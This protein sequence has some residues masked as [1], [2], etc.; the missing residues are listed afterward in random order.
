MDKL[1]S[2]ITVTYSLTALFLLSAC[3]KEMQDAVTS[4]SK[5]ICSDRDGIEVSL[6]LP[7]DGT[8]S[9]STAVETVENGATI[10]FYDC[11]T[12][13]LVAQKSVRGKTTSLI[14]S[15]QPLDSCRVY[16]VANTTFDWP[17]IESEV[18]ERTIQT[19]ATKGYVPRAT[20]TPATWIPGQNKG[21]SHLTLSL[22]K[23]RTRLS[24]KRNVPEGQSFAASEIYLENCP[25][26]IYP[27]L[28]GESEQFTGEGDSATEDDLNAFNSGETISLYAPSDGK[29][30]IVIRGTRT[31]TAGVQAKEKY[32]YP[33]SVGQRQ[34]MII[35]DVT[36]DGKEHNGSTVETESTD[37]RTV[38]FGTD[39]LTFADG[40]NTLN[41]TTVK[42]YGTG[43]TYTIS[44][45]GD[46]SLSGTKLYVGTNSYD[47][48]SNGSFSLNA[49]EETRLLINTAYKGIQRSITL[50][51]TIDGSP[52]ASLVLHIGK[53]PSKLHLTTKSSYPSTTADELSEMIVFNGQDTTLHVFADFTDGTNAE[54]SED[55]SLEWMFFNLGESSA[56][57]QTT[58]SGDAMVLKARYGV[59][60]NASEDISTWYLRHSATTEG[61]AVCKVDGFSDASASFT[62]YIDALQSVYSPIVNWGGVTK[63]LVYAPGSTM[64]VPSSVGV[65]YKYT[66]NKT[67]VIFSDNYSMLMDYTD[68][69]SQV[70]NSR[71]EGD[72][73]LTFKTHTGEYGT[74]STPG[75]ISYGTVK[76]T[77]Y[78]DYE[79]DGKTKS[80]SETVTVKIQKYATALS[81][82][83][84]AI[85]ETNT[86]EVYPVITYND[87]DTCDGL[88][89]SDTEKKSLYQKIRIWYSGGTYG[90]TTST[91]ESLIKQNANGTDKALPNLYV[92]YTG[93]ANGK[94][95]STTYKN[96]PINRLINGNFK[97]APSIG[98]FYPWGWFKSE[99]YYLNLRYYGKTVDNADK[100]FDYKFKV[101]TN[102]NLNDPTI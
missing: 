36:L 40:L 56:E 73:S 93:T 65:I 46:S 88:Y 48:G 23:L 17:K 13:E 99:T 102:H 9:S 49:G 25:K 14:V 76:V 44:W 33:I 57:Y 7:C 52:V 24:I 26:Y 38:S 67:G 85:E 37:T 79:L 8:K 101:E 95:G 72:L 87:G 51:A 70:Q 74:A 80:L 11:N 60:E 59:D 3:S 10:A 32:S 16:A 100:A 35:V 97:T 81:V 66:V 58:S 71:K 18:T 27:F 50:N 15:P 63:V 29:C 5:G 82:N 55:S 78:L 39:Q 4:V 12:T 1:K 41:N 64:T 90:Y 69:S 31:I 34:D 22:N 54:V 53:V 92:W 19:D 96:L 68:P 94:K 77:R 21:T 28:T 86:F 20:T 91:A 43:W 84:E 83:Y 75:Y 47:L 98:V 45:I 2:F 89:L 6:V 42:G 61:T 62:L 30:T